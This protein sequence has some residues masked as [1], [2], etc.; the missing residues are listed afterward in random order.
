MVTTP[1]DTLIHIEVY[2]RIDGI[3]LVGSLTIPYYGL[4]DGLASAAIHVFKR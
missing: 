1:Q 2:D 4:T 3:Q